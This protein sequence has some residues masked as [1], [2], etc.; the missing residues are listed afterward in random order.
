M[1][2]PDT[3]QTAL[4]LVTGDR[5]RQNGEALR[6]HENI[7]LLWTAYK[8]EQFTPQDVA[9]MMALVKIARTQLGE[10]NPDDYIDG[11]GYLAIAGEIAS[12]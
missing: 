12:E 1:K 7:A 8:R 3:L 4:D 5:N 2:A 10:H 11:A 6:N 9:M